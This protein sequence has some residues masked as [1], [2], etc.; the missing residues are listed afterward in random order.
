MYP[1]YD[2]MKEKKNVSLVFLPKM[3]TVNLIMKKPQLNLS[4]WPVLFKN[5]M[6]MKDKVRLR[7]SFHL[8]DTKEK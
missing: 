3:Y 6:V 5:V 8:K 4:N 2:A 1:Q 7:E